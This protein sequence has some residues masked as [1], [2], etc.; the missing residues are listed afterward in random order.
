MYVGWEGVGLCSFLL[1]G[2]WY[3]DPKNGRAA[4]KA[5]IVTRI[6]DTAL[7]IGLFV[8]Y[9]QLGT[10][11][12]GAAMNEAKSVQGELTQLRTEKSTMP[13]M[14]F[15]GPAPA[16]VEPSIP[17]EG[18]SYSPQAYNIHNWKEESDA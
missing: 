14:W 11:Q 18:R 15:A 6:G 3:S 12:I 9:Y 16:K 7:L 5:F 10:L 2:F 8:I 13:R 4:R 17:Q 1:I